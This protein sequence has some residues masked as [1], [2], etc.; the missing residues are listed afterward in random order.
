MNAVRQT[1][2]Q[3]VQSQT[4]LGSSAWASPLSHGRMPGKSAFPRMSQSPP[5]P[6]PLS[7]G[8]VSRLTAVHL[9]SSLQFAK[10]CA[11]LELAVWALLGGASPSQGG[12]PQELTLLPKF[13][14]DCPPQSKTARL[15][16][17]DWRIS[18]L[19]ND[20]PEN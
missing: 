19:D 18:S 14:P 17:L 16:F 11:R 20:F 13:V 6:S 10:Q 15:G 8:P 4:Q 2:V 3:I 1:S 5:F 7:W 12:L 9:E